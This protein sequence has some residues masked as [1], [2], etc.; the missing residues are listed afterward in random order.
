MVCA[1]SLLTIDFSVDHEFF[2]IIALT[3]DII[4]SFRVDVTLIKR[5]WGG[6]WNFFTFLHRLLSLQVSLTCLFD[7]GVDLTGQTGLGFFSFFDRCRSL[8]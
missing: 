8:Q 6:D 4:I 2:E 5:P 1:F 7:R 3:L